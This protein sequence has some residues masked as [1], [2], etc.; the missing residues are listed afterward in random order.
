MLLTIIGV[1]QAEEN[2]TIIQDITNNLFTSKASGSSGL[3]TF[4]VSRQR[5]KKVLINS[6]LFAAKEVFQFDSKKSSWK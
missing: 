3:Q 2:T 1:T 4:H 6:G 5:R